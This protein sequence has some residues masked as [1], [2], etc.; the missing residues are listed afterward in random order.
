MQLLSPDQVT[1]D[2]KGEADTLRVYIAS[3]RAEEKKSLKSLNEVR[4]NSEKEI[5]QI[6]KNLEKVVAESDATIIKCNERVRRAKSETKAIEEYQN[7]VRKD[8]LRP[9]QEIRE[10]AEKLLKEAKDYRADLDR[11][12]EDLAKDRETN[13]ARAEELTEKETGLND[14]KIQLDNRESQIVKEEQRIADGRVL[15]KKDIKANK[16]ASEQN[17][18]R[19]LE[20]DKRTEQIE[21]SEKALN[22]RSKEIDK[23]HI[24]NRNEDVRLRSERDAI[25]TA[26]KHL[27]ISN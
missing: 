5:S 27:G 11:E 25:E 23:R 22:Y 4:L 24:E 3:L 16:E 20:L 21:I 19:S 1:H 26:K 18:L 2:Q 6:N 8:L 14:H 15:L 17:N 12:K 7:T 10:E 13:Q 9:I